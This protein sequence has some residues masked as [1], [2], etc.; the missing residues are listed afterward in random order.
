MTDPCREA[1]KKWWDEYEG[2]DKGLFDVI[3]TMK[4]WQAAWNTRAD[5]PASGVD[6]N[7]SLKQAV[8]DLVKSTIELEKK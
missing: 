6:P 7:H 2:H 4:V 3:Q 5:R 1:F 8:D